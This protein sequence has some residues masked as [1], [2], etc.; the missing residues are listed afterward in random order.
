MKKIEFLNL[1]Q[2]MYYFKHKSGLDVY[3]IP[4]KNKKNF[5]ALL[6]T[7]YGSYDISFELDGKKYTHPYGYLSKKVV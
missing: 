6:G 5:Y 4:Y 3:V 1:D 2:D 7:K